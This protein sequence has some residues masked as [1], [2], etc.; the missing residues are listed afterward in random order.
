MMLIH[1]VKKTKRE[2]KHKSG[3]IVL[4]ENIT[5]SFFLYM[6]SALNFGEKQ[7]YIQE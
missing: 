3:V 6:T 5:I 1:K 4:A 2:K 7:K